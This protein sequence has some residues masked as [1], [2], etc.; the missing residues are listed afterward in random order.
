MENWLLFALSSAVL[1]AIAAITQKKILFEVNALE[2]SFVVSVFNLL[3]AIPFFFM[4]DYSVIQPASLWVLFAKSII[5][6]LAFWCVMLSLKNLDISAALP[7]LALTPG[8]VAIVAFFMIGEEL[9][10]KEIS[11]LMLLLVGTY[12]IDMKNNTDL[13]APFKAFFGSK[14]YYYVFTALALFTVATVMDKWILKGFKL[15]LFPF[16]AFQHLFFA[17]IFLAI[18][19]IGNKSLI[20]SKTILSKRNILL[21]VLVSFLT[22][23]YRF[24]QI[25]AVIIAPVA[26]VTA[27]K[28]ISVFFATI[29]GGKIFNEPHLLRKA[30]AAGIIVVGTLLIA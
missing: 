5:N 20:P 19:V 30:I 28:R 29:A 27:V 21:T 1:S 3:L 10:I 15:G 22:I 8:F 11:G 18:F 7:L 6:A 25:S 2:F 12:I 24:T 13:L 23:G 16:M 4:F 14:K 26:L 17:L 9:T